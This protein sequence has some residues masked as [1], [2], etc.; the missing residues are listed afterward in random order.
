MGIC[1]IGLHGNLSLVCHVFYEHHY[2]KK[3]NKLAFSI[4]RRRRVKRRS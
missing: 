3:I 1:K 2:L 4:V